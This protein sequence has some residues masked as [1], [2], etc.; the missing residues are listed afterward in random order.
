M[1]AVIDAD[2]LQNTEELNLKINS[3]IKIIPSKKI[4]SFQSEFCDK[5]CLS[6]G[7]LKKHAT[8]KH[9]SSKVQEILSSDFLKS[10]VVPTREMNLEAQILNG[11]FQKSLCKLA[12]R[13]CYPDTQFN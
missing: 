1:M 10:D 2:M 5:V 4:L 6:S 13:R 11:F 3:W 9:L 8:K 12:R 7:G